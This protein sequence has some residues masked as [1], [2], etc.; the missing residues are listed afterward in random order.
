MFDGKTSFLVLGILLSMQSCSS[1]GAGHSAATPSYQGSNG[2]DTNQLFVNEEVERPTKPNSLDAD[3]LSG[4][5]SIADSLLEIVKQAKEKQRS[6]G[7]LNNT[8]P[9]QE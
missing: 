2:P 9:I 6:R 5:V 3:M 7:T 4:S 1:C 8:A